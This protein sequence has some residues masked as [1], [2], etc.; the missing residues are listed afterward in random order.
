MELITTL[1][2]TISHQMESVTLPHTAENH[3][4]QVLL[5]YIG[6]DQHIHW[7]IILH[8]QQLYLRYCDDGGFQLDNDISLHCV[9]SVCLTE[10]I[11]SYP[12]WYWTT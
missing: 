1:M 2:G 5:V 12:A 6:R 8:Y 11:P 10:W 4:Q 7:I 9:C 3:P